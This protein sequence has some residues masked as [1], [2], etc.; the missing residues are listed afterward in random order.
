MLCLIIA[1]YGIG[2]AISISE[3]TTVYHC[4]DDFSAVD[5]Y[6]KDAE[7]SDVWLALIW[8]LALSFNTVLFIL[9]LLNALI[10]YPLL[11]IGIKYK[12]SRLDNIIR[13]FCD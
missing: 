1:I 10:Q 3:S 5:T 6:T 4:R 7:T 8:P 9:Y 13:K 11:L 2:F 12:N